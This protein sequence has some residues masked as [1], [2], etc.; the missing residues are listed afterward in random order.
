[1]WDEPNRDSKAN[2]S[3]NKVREK[4]M[5]KVLNKARRRLREGDE[6]DNKRRLYLY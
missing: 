4:M 3:N 2:G 5:G 1:M 6:R